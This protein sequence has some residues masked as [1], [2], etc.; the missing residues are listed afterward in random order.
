LIV[1]VLDEELYNLLAIVVLICVAVELL[2][3]SLAE[4]FQF[5]INISLQPFQVLVCGDLATLGAAFPFGSLTVIEGVQ[6]AFV[7]FGAY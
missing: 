4:C 2:F 5:V 1:E 7:G 6:W 3:L